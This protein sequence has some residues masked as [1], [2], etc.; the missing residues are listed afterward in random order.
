MSD[1]KNVQRQVKSE[2]RF[3]L[4]LAA[5]LGIGYLVFVYPHTNDFS[6]SDSEC[7]DLEA[8]WSESLQRKFQPGDGWKNVDPLTCPSVEASFA[9][10]MRF[11]ET[12]DLDI[13]GRA[14]AK[15]YFDWA[16][17]LKPVFG[18]AP[19]FGLAGRTRFE[20]RAID[21]SPI[22]MD[23]ANWVQIAGVIVHELRHLEQG[24]NTHVPCVA[25]TGMTCDRRLD[26]DPMRG[27]AY[28]YN[29]L[30]L[31]QVRQSSIATSYEK[32]LAER[33]MQSIIDKRF[34]EIDSDLYRILK[35]NP[36][37]PAQ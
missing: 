25:E 36:K 1:S 2:F 33:E 4:W 26:L 34:N 27:D 5:V 28:S 24:I 17:D 9:K 7:R 23:K 6:I 11:I 35:L 31:H 29:I 15:T 12:V 30:F 13:A 16:T 8:Y 37:N 32:K 22:L 14:P 10:A 21:I 20:Q 3:L 19:L 18:Q